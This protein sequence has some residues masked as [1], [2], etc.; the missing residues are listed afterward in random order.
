MDPSSSKDASAVTRLPGSTLEIPLGGDALVEVAGTQK[1]FKSIFVGMD[2]EHFILLK[3]PMKRQ[4]METL[5]PNLPLTVRFLME[6]GKVCGFQAQVTH[7]SVKPHPLLYLSYPQTLEILKLRRHDRVACYQPV[8]FF[9]E[10]EEYKG[11]IVNISAGGCRILVE[12]EEART[13]EDKA[14]GEQLV[15]QLRLFGSEESVYL[16]GL[17]KTITPEQEKF[18][19]GVAF[20]DID[21]ELAMQIEKYVTTMLAYQ[22]V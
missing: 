17:V 10:G 14:V 15:F 5:S 4:I 22:Q 21:P 7:L 13:L 16:Q 8:A 6:G 11:I 9:L 18:T 20:Q 3:L 2:K 1:R 19:L 12:G